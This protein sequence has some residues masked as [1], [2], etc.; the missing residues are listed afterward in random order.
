[1]TWLCLDALL[2]EIV[3]LYHKLRTFAPGPATSVDEDEPSSALDDEMSSPMPA[4]LTLERTA[5]TTVDEKNKM[6]SRAKNADEDSFHRLLRLRSSVEEYNRRLEDA[7][8]MEE[9]DDL[10]YS[11]R[12]PILEY[13]G[14]HDWHL[15][16]KTELE[17]MDD[18]AI[19]TEYTFAHMLDIASESEYGGAYTKYNSEACPARRKREVVADMKK[20]AVST[21]DAH[22]DAQ[23]ADAEAADRA[24]DVVHQVRIAQA[25]AKESADSMRLAQYAMDSAANATGRVVDA[26]AAVQAAKSSGDADA[27]KQAEDEAAEA[28]RDAK[29][30][31][32]DAAE[33]TENHNSAVIDAA[34]AFDMYLEAK[35]IA[36]E[37][38]FFA[39]AA[40]QAA[41]E[42]ELIDGGD[43]QSATK[44]QRRS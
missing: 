15:D 10:Y 41:E 38:L 17:I 16:F 39:E 7:K 14:S 36:A 22:V 34:N 5:E 32:D 35:S 37:A 31:A 2:A 33:K 6:T 11:V 3:K 23:I 18:I 43:A 42:L 4:P 27:I 29:S 25:A 21:V 40:A 19:N 30:Y 24:D 26:F 13:I 12:R 1:M 9:I 28:V 44:K 20:T 8:T